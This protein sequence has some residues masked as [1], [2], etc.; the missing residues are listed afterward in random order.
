[1]VHNGW[2]AIDGYTDRSF[3]LQSA[4]V[5][6][7]LTHSQDE[8]SQACTAHGRA[9]LL[10]T[11]RHSNPLDLVITARAWTEVKDNHTKIFGPI[12]PS[13]GVHE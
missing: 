7:M 4:S 11:L 8:N 1:M 5:C 13:S 12:W 3:H 6:L 9:A 10:Q 2:R